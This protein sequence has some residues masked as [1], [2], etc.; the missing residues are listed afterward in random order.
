[1]ICRYKST[2][3]SG[4]NEDN[5]LFGRSG[6]DSLQNAAYNKIFDKII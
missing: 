3:L 5:P 2:N 1:M 6:H 4:E